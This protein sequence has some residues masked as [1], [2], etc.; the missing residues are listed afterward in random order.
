VRKGP[1]K[2]FFVARMLTT[3]EEKEWAIGPF[4]VLKQRVRDIDDK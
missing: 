1:D 4:L 3:G 2:G